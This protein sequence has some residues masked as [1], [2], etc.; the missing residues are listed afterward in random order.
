MSAAQPA[1]PSS[2]PPVNT[3]TGA[4]V[5]NL[6]KHRPQRGGDRQIVQGRWTPM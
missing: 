4:T 2:P 3:G 6:D 5:I 1:Q